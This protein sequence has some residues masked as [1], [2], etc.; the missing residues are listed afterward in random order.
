MT[1]SIMTHENTK[2]RQL[3]AL[4]DA[5][6][7][8]VNGGALNCVPVFGE[9]GRMYSPTLDGMPGGP[10]RDLLGLLRIPFGRGF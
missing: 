3:R 5:E 6:I 9:D 8:L 4:D 10:L 1:T 2:A 7:E